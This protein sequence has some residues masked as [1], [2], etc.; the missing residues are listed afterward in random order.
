MAVPK[1][2][3]S[4]SRKGLRHAGQHHKEYAKSVVK[5]PTTGEFT[6]PH[7]V[8]P[9]GWYKGVKIFKTRAEKAAEAEQ[10]ETEN[11]EN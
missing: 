2:K 3:T 11:T 9:G 8:S 6:L 10:E 4:V 7:R 5:C 1:K